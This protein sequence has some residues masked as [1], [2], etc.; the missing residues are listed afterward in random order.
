MLGWARHTVFFISGENQHR[1]A[2]QVESRRLV[3]EQKLC[4]DWQKKRNKRRVNDDY[5]RLD[6]E[7]FMISD[8]CI[9]NIWEEDFSYSIFGPAGAL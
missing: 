9:A 8:Y 7:R 2:A 4:D 1:R 6:V 5:G 3:D